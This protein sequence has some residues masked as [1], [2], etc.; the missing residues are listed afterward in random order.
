[1]INC[2]SHPAPQPLWSLATQYLHP[3]SEQ[4]S[5]VSPLRI[6]GVQIPVLSGSTPMLHI[7]VNV[8]QFLSPIHLLMINADLVPFTIS[9]ITVISFVQEVHLSRGIGLRVVL[10]IF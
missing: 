8:Q 4:Y 7:A 1:M 3:R 6:L 9:E 5:Y 10:L 2:L